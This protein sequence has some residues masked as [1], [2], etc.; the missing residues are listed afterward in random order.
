MIV[1]LPFDGIWIDMNEPSNFLTF[2]QQNASTKA[3]P[4]LV[5]PIGGVDGELDNPPYATYAA[6]HYGPVPQMQ[7]ESHCLS[8]SG[9]V[10]VHWDIVHARQNRRRVVE[11]LRHEEPLRLVGDSRDGQSTR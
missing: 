2:V 8:L 10:F 1:Q 5:C 7:Q 3:A 11:L 6:Y 4:N 9:I